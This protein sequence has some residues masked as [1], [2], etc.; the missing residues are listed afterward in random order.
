MKKIIPVLMLLL[1][2]AACSTQKKV[3]YF[4]D[5][6]DGGS[7]K[8]AAPQDIKLKAGDQFTIHV[9]S[10]DQELAQPF[11]LTRSASGGSGSETRLA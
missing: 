4:Q 7:V 6:T 9:N 3:P 2:T 11:N 1:L 8:I 5:L 10:K